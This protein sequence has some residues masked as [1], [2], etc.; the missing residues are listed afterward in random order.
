MS[1]CLRPLGL[2]IALLF[3]AAC[4]APGAG[5]PAKPA[6]SAPAPTSAGAGAQ[7]TPASASGASTTAQ[8]AGFASARLPA[9]VTIKFGYTPLLSGGP[10]FVGLE[11]GYFEQLNINL[12]MVRFNSGALMVAPLANNDLDAGNGGL[13]PGLYNALMRD[14]RL[15]LVADG[16]SSKAG[17]GTSIAMVRKDLWDAG[18]VRVP[19]DLRGKRVSFATEGSPIDYMMRNLLRQ[20]GMTMDEMDVS[21]LT[22]ADALV[23]LQNRAVDVA[24]AAEPFP[25]QIE[26][27]GA[28]VKW[29]SDGDVVPGFQIGAIMFSE[30]FA[31]QPEIGRAFMVAYVRAIREYLDADSGRADDE[32]VAAISKW[33]TVPPD[34]IKA[35][36]APHFNP[37]GQLSLEDMNRQQDFWISEGVMKDKV[38]MSQFVDLGYVEYANQVLGPR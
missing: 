38:D 5:A 18:A 19:T 1:A 26:A 7:A 2:L 12:D 28:A 29:L 13:S 20:N 31:S 17:A 16:Q 37:S 22:S 8:P 32:M 30:R 27:M 33:T 4:A 14:V 9:P 21:H 6:A 25:S 36:G 23:G 3:M 11:R 35:A 24:T 15:R 10:V 34:A